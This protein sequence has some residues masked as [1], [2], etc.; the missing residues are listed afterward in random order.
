MEA[1]ADAGGPAV[2]AQALTKRYGRRRGVQD[3]SFAV[4][5]GEI[6]ALLG[7]NGAGKTTAMRL[8]VG[9]SRP[10][11]GSARLLGRQSRLA[12]DVLARVGVLIDGPAFVPHLSGLTNL[13]LLWRAG[14][15]EWPPPALD[16]SLALAG[17]GSG[18][19]RKVKGYSTGMRQ[20]LAL[21]QAL[22]GDPD[23]LVLD[24]PAN[25]L[26]PGEIRALREHLGRLARDGAAILISS[27]LLAEVEV[28]ASHAVVIDGGVVA[29]AGPL[30]RLLG[31]G[32]AAQRLED[33]FLA[34]VSQGR[35]RHDERM[36]RPD[37][38]G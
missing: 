21:A 14:G 15:R 33:V 6:C 29:A 35:E 37:G 23:V 18:I 3:V 1:T 7:P 22:M 38:K 36:E 25:G 24:E 32:A 17:L 30:D 2:A 26:D 19:D 8:L 34:L 20:R 12:A 16:A 10:D 27:H 31:Q 13:K 28:L 4:Q 9:L 5:H 11:G